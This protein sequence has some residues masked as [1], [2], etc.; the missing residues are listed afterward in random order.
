MAE[1][2]S[3]PPMRSEQY[4][5]KQLGD[6]CEMLVAAELTLAGI[7]AL[8]VP[9]NWPGY[10]VVAQPLGAPPQR[11]SVKGRTYQRQ[12][13]HFAD[14]Y[15]GAEEFDW[16][17]IVLLPNADLAERRIYI[18]PKSAFDAVARTWPDKKIGRTQRYVALV[19]IEP[20]FRAFRNNFGLKTE[21]ELIAPSPG[22]VTGFLTGAAVEIE[23]HADEE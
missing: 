5:T 21:A 9:D 23:A 2:A 15:E 7:P 12:S 3:G 17:A 10:D 11:I 19:R 1:L 16:I 14:Y 20:L 22:A 6:A 8:K 4:T 13:S 18:I